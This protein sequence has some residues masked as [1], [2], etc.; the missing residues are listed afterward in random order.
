MGDN[1]QRTDYTKKNAKKIIK[2]LKE[3]WLLFP[4]C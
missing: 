2:K 3:L 1:T 4:N